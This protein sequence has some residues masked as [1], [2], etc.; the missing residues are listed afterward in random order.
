MAFVVPPAQTKYKLRH[1]RFKLTLAEAL[2]A[3]GEL[4]RMPE[5]VHRKTL[6]RLGEVGTAWSLEDR[7]MKAVLRRSKVDRVLFRELTKT[8]EKL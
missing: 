1:A 2:T 8:V 6:E 7:L 4:T 5:L 3:A